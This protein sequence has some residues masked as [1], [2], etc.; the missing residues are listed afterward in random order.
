VERFLRKYDA[1]VWIAFFAIY[2]SICLWLTGC[3]SSPQIYPRKELISWELRPRTGHIGLTSQRCIKYEKEKCIELDLVEFDLN[4]DEDR[5]RLHDAR[6]VCRVEVSPRPWYRICRELHGLCQQAE[7]T[8]G[9]WFN[10]KKEIK[11][12]SFIDINKG[13]NFLIDSGA[14]CISLNNPLSSEL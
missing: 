5:K 4:K 1:I 6:F 8:T 11:L 3:S 14:Y 12:I 13:Y 2:I 10:R 7:I 9:S